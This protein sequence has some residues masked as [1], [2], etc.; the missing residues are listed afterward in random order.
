MGVKFSNTDNALSDDVIMSGIKE[1]QDSKK[2]IIFENLK[3][4]FSALYETGT[5]IKN[6]G[7]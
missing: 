5:I 1:I 4:Y 7:N 3:N 6:K 2:D